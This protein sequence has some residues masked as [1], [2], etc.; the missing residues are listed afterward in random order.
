MPI[1]GIVLLIFF[2]ASLPVCFVRPFYGILLWTIVA[3]LNP[4]SF[5]WRTA[6]TG[7]V[8]TFPWAM[9]VA[10]PTLIG[11]PL[12]CRGWMRRL[13]VREV[14]LLVALWVWF[15]I[16]SVVSANTPLFQHHADDT[17]YRWDFV[18]KV[19]L[20]TLVTIAVVDNFEKLRVLVM[21][22]AG[23][24]G[25]FVLKALPFMILTGGTFR[26][27]GPERSMVADNNDLGLAF[28]MTLP[29]FFFLAQ[30]ESRRWLKWFYAFLGMITVPAI[31]FT[32]SR[33]ALVGLV[34]VF[35]LMFLQW[36]RRFILIPV[37]T[38]AAL[39]AMLFAPE[40]WKERMDPMRPDAVDGSARSRLN[41]WTFSLR[42]ANDYPIAGGGFE[43]FTQPLFDRYAPNP[44]DVHGPHSIYFG[45]LAEHGYIGLL[46]YLSLILSCFAGTSRVIKL[47]RL[48]RD[49]LVLNYGNMF[50][51]SLVA[52]LVSGAF[53][54]RAYFDYFLAIVACMTILRRLSFSRWAAATPAVLVP[55]EHAA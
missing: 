10:I 11:L 25:F 36:K 8:S 14:L 30:N 47:A 27:Y 49:Q 45:V 5:I 23:C 44:I 6:Y 50:R 19:F 12:F 51:F 22:M 52:F 43:T 4:Q 41:S 55:K 9:A 16:T 2:L 26:L 28:N 13:A 18:S 33:G 1:R 39:I 15:T 34:V 31:F 17:W 37:V 54:G 42:L 3:F 48:H 40:A 21:V 35:G 29:L 24:F 46:L 53:L 32:Y 20:M 38:V 7:F